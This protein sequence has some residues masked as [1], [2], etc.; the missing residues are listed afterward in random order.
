MEQVVIAPGVLEFQPSSRQLMLTA[1]YLRVYQ[2]F[3]CSVLMRL[4]SADCPALVIKAKD[5]TK[6]LKD[7][8]LRVA[9]SFIKSG[10][11]NLFASFVDF[12]APAPPKCPF[13]PLV[14]FEDIQ[15]LD[16][17]ENRNRLLQQLDTKRLHIWL[18]EGGNAEIKNDI[19]KATPIAVHY[20]ATV[21]LDDDFRSTLRSLALQHF[22]EHLKL[23]ANRWNFQAAFQE[24]SREMPVT[25]SPVLDSDAAQDPRRMR[26]LYTARPAHTCGSPALFVEA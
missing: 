26:C 25:R 17:E 1:V 6:L 15:G 4:D 10:S 18:A 19:M 3:W 12:D 20:E 5:S 7:H 13:A 23:G 24:F 2:S 21:D 16:H 8:P 9:L 22:E 11:G 14:V